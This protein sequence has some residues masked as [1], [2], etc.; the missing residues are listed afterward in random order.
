MISIVLADDH[1]MFID[2]IKE[3]LS[4]EASIRI[5]GEALNGKD[6]LTLLE[7]QRPNIVLMDINMPLLD[8]LEAT[9]IIHK[10]YPDIKV[11]MLTMFDTK[12]FITR[13]IS[14]GA[15][16]Y[17][18]KSAGKDELIT[19]IQAVHSGATFYSAEMTSKVMESYRKK[20]SSSQSQIVELTPREMEV[21]KLFAQELTAYEIAEKLNI[22]YSTVETH[23]KHM[24][25]KC[26]VRTTV[27]L[28][29]WAI[30]NRM[31]QE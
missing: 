27:G 6:L 10:E 30:E 31:L 14:V 19:A 16:G 4:K 12:D 5:V 1:Q 20:S 28:V 11:I 29:K 15:R 23:R 24:I 26:N 21:L 18:L 7:S 3:M 22:S 8:G 9:R 2:G 17:I 13:M 25:S